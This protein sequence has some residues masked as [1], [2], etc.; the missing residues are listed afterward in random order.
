MK[1]FINLILASLLVSCGTTNKVKEMDKNDIQKKW[2]LSVLDGNEIRAKQPVYIELNND[3][4]VNGFAGCNRLMGS[5]TIENG[6]QIKF[7]Q[8]STT[9]MACRDMKLER[10]VLEILNSSDGFTID[11][12]K[13]MLNIGSKSALAIFREMTTE[14]IVNKYWKLKTLNGEEVEMSV[15]QEREQNF[16][17]RS[18][19]SLA[20][21]GGCN[22][23]IGTFKLTNGN[24]IEFNE[25]RITTLNACADLK[26]KEDA[27][28]NV[29]Y[30]TD[31][32]KIDG[33][34]LQLLEGKEKSLA[35]F[36]A[37]YF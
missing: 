19:G 1:F 4:K 25:T 18:D 35:S 36:E 12:G 13:L 27:F 15:D 10:R 32:Y 29:F 31:N 6:N 3:N 33:D 23:F 24:R 2:E 14:E 11:D 8:L 22:H 7:N 16:I 28:L 20:G 5:Y 26:V 9:R 17:L 37:I 34:R 21:F 30:S